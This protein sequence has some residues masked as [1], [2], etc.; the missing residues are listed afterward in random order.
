[1][2]RLETRVLKLRYIL[3]IDFVALLADPTYNYINPNIKSPRPKEPVRTLLPRGVVSLSPD[4]LKQ[5]I[6]VQAK[7]G[8]LDELVALLRLLD[9]KTKEVVM[10]LNIGDSQARVQVQN[11]KQAR[12]SVRSEGKSYSLDV[13]PHIDSGG[14]VSFFVS[15]PIRD[16]L[17]VINWGS[18]KAGVQDQE[19]ELAVTFRQVA[20]GEPI[21]FK[22]G[23]A[24]VTLTAT[25][26]PV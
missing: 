7:S 23:S 4:N 5:E 24:T 18:A 1:M 26:V 19:N 15:I 11:N 12:L 20:F 21:S 22:W 14:S 17:V 10:C 25:P 3:P 2:R 9:V 16:D 8:A 13:V 6:T